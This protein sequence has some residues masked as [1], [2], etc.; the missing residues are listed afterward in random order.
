MMIKCNTGSSTLK[1]NI[2]FFLCYKGC[3]GSRCQNW[4]MNG[5]IRKSIVADLLKLISTLW[6]YKS[7]LILRKPTLK[8]LVVKGHDACNLLSNGSEIE[9]G[10]ASK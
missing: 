1:D 7:F 2:G 4:N 8:N 9:I 3:I 10:N 5:E 6:L